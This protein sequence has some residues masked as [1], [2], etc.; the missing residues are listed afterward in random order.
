MILRYT[1][2]AVLRQTGTQGS[3]ALL[4]F[5]ALVGTVHEVSRCGKELSE[6]PRGSWHSGWLTRGAGQVPREESGELCPPREVW[7]HSVQNA[8]VGDG[9][10]LKL[11]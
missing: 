3:R 10:K 4:A 7:N 6:S 11:F 8:M 2:I 5:R 1:E 9:N